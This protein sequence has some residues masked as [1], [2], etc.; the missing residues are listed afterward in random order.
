MGITYKLLT[1]FVILPNVV[2]WFV[3]MSKLLFLS[4]C[5]HYKHY[6]ALH[7]I[8]N[9]IQYHWHPASVHLFSHSSF[10]ISVLL[11]IY[12]RC[13]LR[14]CA[15]ECVPPVMNFSLLHKFNTFRSSSSFCPPCA[16]LHDGFKTMLPSYS[17]PSLSSTFSLFLLLV[18]LCMKTFKVV[19]WRYG[20]CAYPLCGP[21]WDEKI[22]ATLT[23]A[24]AS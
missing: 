2:K 23:Y 22:Y 1:F 16:W 20:K 24:A 4:G 7:F 3:F 15:P 6:A 5:S 11:Y 19:V 8:L 14:V 12:F 13:A 10:P 21:E 9:A 18:W 17:F